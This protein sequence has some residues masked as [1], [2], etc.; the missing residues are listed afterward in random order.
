MPLPFPSGGKE[1]DGLPEKMTELPFILKGMM[2]AREA[3]MAVEI[4]AAGIV[5]SNHDHVHTNGR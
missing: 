2:T 1:M 3:E 5:V 4:G